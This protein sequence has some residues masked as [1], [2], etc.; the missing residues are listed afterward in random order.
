MPSFDPL[1]FRQQFSC[2]K[3]NPNMG[4]Y[5]DNAA[6]TQLPDVVIEAL[7]AHYRRGRSNVHRSSHHLAN[8]VGEQF[9]HARQVVAD[10]FNASAQQ[11]IWTNGTTDGINRIAHGL[12]GRFSTGQ[13]I[14]VS[15]MEHHANLVPWQQLCLRDELTL[16]II[17][18]NAQGELDISALQTLLETHNVALV[19]CCH[20]ANSLGIVNDVQ[21][22]TQ[23]AHQ[24][25]AYCI[26]DGA[27]A[28]AHLPIDSQQINADAYVFSGHKMYAPT[29]VGA[30]IGQADFLE[31][32]TPQ[33]FGGEM[34]SHVDYFS[35]QFRELPYRL[36]AGTPN[37]D[38]V[39][40][41]ARAC[42]FLN[43]F[44]D[45]RQAYEAQLYA[46]A[47]TQLETIDAIRLINHS[48]TACSIL[49][50]EPHNIHPFDLTSWLNENN[51]AIRCGYHCAMPVTESLTQS[52]S[53]RLSLCAYNTQTEIDQFMT[54][55]N[56][57]IAI[58][59]L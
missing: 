39:I 8:A 2:F 45:G 35:A 57:G 28:V 36:E 1:L 18:F 23:L 38:G 11:V 37:I 14:L 44:S 20:V 49:A 7:M 17:P 46:Y 5:F 6:T 13:T 40:G 12:T 3:D 27:Q 41:L 25:Q 51:I 16:E 42:Q 26:I 10:Y 56:S 22:I 59:L 31:Q 30:I 4:I 47:K 55:L 19:A 21:T 52:G 15:A 34:V 24:Y 58:N 33:I 54:I 29:G 50:F 9:E 53:I 32:L 43:T 48:D